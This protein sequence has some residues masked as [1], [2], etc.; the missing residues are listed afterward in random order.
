M[1]DLMIVWDLS[2]TELVSEGNND[3]KS[4]EVS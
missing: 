3:R 1:D 2:A 4:R